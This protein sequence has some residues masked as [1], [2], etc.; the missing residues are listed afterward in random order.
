M[1][2]TAI[3]APS[4]PTAHPTGS[5]EARAERHIATIEDHLA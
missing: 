4:A 2:D 5:A 3:R 1:L